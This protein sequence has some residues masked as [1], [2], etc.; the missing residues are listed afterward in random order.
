MEPI[1]DAGKYAGTGKYA[2]RD[3]GSK[4]GILSF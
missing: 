4:N 2:G 3:D 1:I